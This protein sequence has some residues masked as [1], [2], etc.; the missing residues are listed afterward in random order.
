MRLLIDTR[1]KQFTVTKEAEPRFNRD[2][3]CRA[4]I[5][6]GRAFVFRALLRSTTAAVR[7][8]P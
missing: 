7:S 6:D 8:S 5:G 2:S 1:Q 4:Q 3:E